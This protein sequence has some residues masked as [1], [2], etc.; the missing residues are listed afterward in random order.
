MPSVSISNSHQNDTQGDEGLFWK[1]YI[2]LCIVRLYEISQQGGLE[3][4]LLLMF[5]DEENSFN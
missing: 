5:K 2:K 3:G 4:K 1:V